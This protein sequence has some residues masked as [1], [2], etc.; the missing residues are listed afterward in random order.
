MKPTPGD[1]HIN[2]PLTNISIAYV[3]NANNFVAANVFPNIPVQH[4]SDIYWKTDRTDFNRDD[5]EI[6]AP[7]TETAGV[8]WKP[9][10]DT[11][12][13]PV[14][15]LHHDISDQVRSNADSVF[16]LDKSATLLLTSK[17]LI[18]REKL[19]A[20]AYFKTGVWANGVNGVA[21][22]ATPGTSVLQWNDANSNPIEDIRTAKATVLAL[23]GF[24]PNKLVLSRLVYDKL[25]DHPDL[26]DRI[27]YSGGVGNANPAIISRQAMAALFE[28]DQIV[29]AQAIENTAKEGAAEANSFI[30]G[31]GALLCYAPDAPGVDVPSAGYTFSWN[32]Y[33][34]AGVQGNRIKRFR[35][36]PIASDRI[37]IEMAYATKITGSDLGY[38]FNT[39][40][41]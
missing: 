34:G 5:M 39:I 35:I 26:V 30:L 16:A 28:V 22:G 27:K 19:W 7:A 14:Y 4:Q 13:C 20:A 12:Y 2:A 24:E 17:A 31:K 37:E 15:G 25:L 40:I 38:Y 8:G 1:V 32:G 21:S 18:K 11:Y 3:Q 23:T 9:S 36:E 10:T 6:R 33:T 29:V 41:A